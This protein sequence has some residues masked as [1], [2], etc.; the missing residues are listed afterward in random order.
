[1]FGSVLFGKIL[2]TLAFLGLIVLAFRFPREYIFG[3]EQ[4][5][6]YKDLRLW[7]VFLV[8]VLILLY[9]LF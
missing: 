3:E 2:A 9:W 6:L 4:Y 7:V 1:M 5:S 8:L